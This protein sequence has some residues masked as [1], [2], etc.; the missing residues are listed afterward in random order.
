M[1]ETAKT[2]AKPAAKSGSGAMIVRI[3][4][5]GILGALLVVAGLEFKTKRD[6]ENSVNMIDFGKTAADLEK[7][8]EGSYEVADGKGPGV[9]FYIW[10]GLLREY[11]VKVIFAGTKVE[12]F[13]SIPEEMEE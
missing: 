3:A 13:T 2:E 9:K 5:F 7:V 8:F 1:N 11:R 6:F 10:K 4:V 12:K